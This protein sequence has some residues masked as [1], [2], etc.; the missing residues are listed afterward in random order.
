[1]TQN[2]KWLIK[3]AKLAEEKNEEWLKK[4]NEEWL[5]FYIE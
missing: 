4:K 3:K 2:K 1:M 5:T